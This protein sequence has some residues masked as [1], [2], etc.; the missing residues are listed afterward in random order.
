M[1]QVSGLNKSLYGGGHKVD[2]LNKINLVIPTGQFIAITGA[3]GSG[4]TTLLSLIAGLD[5]PT[6][7]KII[8]DKPYS[9]GLIKIVDPDLNE[10]SDTELICGNSKI[11]ILKPEWM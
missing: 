3:S 9:F 10:F 1:I 7:G 4:K 2:I 11:I 5:E 6:Q 8:I